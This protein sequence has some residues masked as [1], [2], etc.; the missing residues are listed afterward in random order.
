MA[1]P[2]KHISG[3]SVLGS[4]LIGFCGLITNMLELLVIML[5][6]YYVFVQVFANL[7]GVH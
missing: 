7:H 3:W 4:F 2:S 5:F 6:G 1:F